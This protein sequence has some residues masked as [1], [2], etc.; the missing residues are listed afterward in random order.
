MAVGAARPAIRHREPAGRRQQYRHRGGRACA[1]RTATRSSWSVRRHAINATLYDKLNFNF[2]RDIAPVAGIIRDALRHG[3]EPIG[4]RPRQ[5]PSS[6]PMPRPI[7][8]RS[9]WRRAATERAAHLAGELLKMMAGINMVHVPYRGAAPA[10]TDLL[11]GQVQV[12]FGPMPASIEHI[13][14]GKLRRTGGDN[15]NAF[16]GA[17]GHPD[18]GRFRARATRRARGQASARP[19][20]RPP[21][22]SRSSTRRSMP[23]SPIPR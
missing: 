20:T 1:R 8:A 6:S 18:G 16:G 23:A 11:G 21:R 9:T 10:L 13:R 14:A 22:S 2:L 3:G 7:R 19:R 15:C 17:A 12:M 4:S 5:F